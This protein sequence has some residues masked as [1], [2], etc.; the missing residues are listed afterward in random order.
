MFIIPLLNLYEIFAVTGTFYAVN[1][2]RLGIADPVVIFQ[3]L[4]A[5]G[6]LTATLFGAALFPILLAMLLGRAW[7]GWMCPY[8]LAAYGVAWIRGRVKKTSPGQDAREHLVV[9]S[10]FNA[11]IW[12]YGFLMLGT[13]AAGAVGIPVLNYVS[14]PGILSTEAMI[15][16]KEHAVSLELG[17]IALILLLELL[18]L[19]RFWCRLFCPTGAF[20]ALFRLPFT[21]RVGTD[22][23][24]PRSPCCKE[25]H[26]TSACPMGLS[27]FR[28]G[29]NLLCTN[30]GRC[31]DACR[32]NGGP[33]RLRFK[34][35]AG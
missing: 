4:F 1:I 3:A 26:C 32:A 15:L 7:C 31:I 28:E 19:P 29:S 27:P 2:G 30:C 33:G 10:S 18:V 22:A 20:L 11:N 24:N 5:S 16:V 13:G 34:G 25:N 17:F 35:F 21:L 23:G 14:A 6:S 12:R 8:H 9:S